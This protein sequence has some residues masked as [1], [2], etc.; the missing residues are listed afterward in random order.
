[1]AHGW[2][3]NIQNLKFTPSGIRYFERLVHLE[4]DS[5]FCAIAQNAKYNDMQTHDVLG[6]TWPV[7]IPTH[8]IRSSLQHRYPP[9]ADEL[10]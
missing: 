9:L 6:N 7:I 3:E 1:M 4:R 5:D 2:I 8:H 10:T